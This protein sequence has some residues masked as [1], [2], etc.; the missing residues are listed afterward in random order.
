MVSKSEY[1]GIDTVTYSLIRAT[2]TL[3]R[4][5][6]A[7]PHT[8]FPYIDP[9]LAARTFCFPPTLFSDVTVHLES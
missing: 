9:Y 4:L 2:H 8:S 5:A 6:N 7:E 1:L 3:T